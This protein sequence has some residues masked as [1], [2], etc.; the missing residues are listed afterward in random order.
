MEIIKGNAMQ[1]HL[2]SMLCLTLSVQC[3]V[4]AD[5]MPQ[6]SFTYREQKYTSIPSN[7]KKER[8]SK[9]GK[10]IR[11]EI[12]TATEPDG[13]TLILEKT[14]YD[15]HPV[16]EWSLSFENRSTQD[17]GRFTRIS[18]ADFTIPFA[19]NESVTLWKGIGEAPNPPDN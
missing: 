10:D 2:L 17:T 12:I 7:W 15:K 8:K 1:K 6:F 14:V 9:K 5:V 11:S 4:M 19:P 13:I 3:A 18:S 16:V